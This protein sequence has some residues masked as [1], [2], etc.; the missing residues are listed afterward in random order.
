M[1]RRKP[2]VLRP[3]VPHYTTVEAVDPGRE[4]QWIQ[5]GMAPLPL[6]AEQ[7]ADMVRLRTATVEFAHFTANA[8]YIP[9]GYTV[10]DLLSIEP[11][12]PGL[13]PLMSYN[14][15]LQGVAL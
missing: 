2:I 13:L 11:L 9:T 8:S 1:S 5:R 7:E 12:F 4:T 3:G 10:D 14:G 15:A 6:T